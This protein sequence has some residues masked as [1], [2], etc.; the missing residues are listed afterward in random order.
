MVAPSKCF[1]CDDQTTPLRKFN[2]ERFQKCQFLLNVRKHLNLKY[3]GISS[4]ENLQDSIGY[5][6]VLQ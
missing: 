6:A 1:L 5:H 2:E 3:N 4:L